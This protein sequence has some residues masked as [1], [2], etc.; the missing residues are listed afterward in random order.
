MNKIDLENKIAIVTGGAQ[1]FGLAITKRLIDSGASVIIWDIDDKATS[2]AIDEI[3]SEKCISQ[4]VDVTNFTEIE[5]SLKKITESHGRIDIFINNAGITGMN[6][7]LWDYPVDEWNK[8][9]DLDLNATFYCCKAANF[10]YKQ[11]LGACWNS[12]K[13]T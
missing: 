1:G 12:K 2:S 4:K 11:Q 9:I 13:C 8:V 7:K 10:F 3:N 6:A 5:N